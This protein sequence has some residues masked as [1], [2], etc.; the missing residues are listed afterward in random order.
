MR[1]ARP[2]CIEGIVRAREGEDWMQPCLLVAEVE[3]LLKS[4]VEFGL[5]FLDFRKRWWTPIFLHSY[6]F[7]IQRCP[8]LAMVA[9]GPVTAAA[10]RSLGVEVDVVSSKVW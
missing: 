8:G 3:G 5:G 10:A 1:W 4:F 9:Y 6:F 7:V 2:R